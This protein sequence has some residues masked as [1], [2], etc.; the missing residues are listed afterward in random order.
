MPVRSADAVK[1]KKQVSQQSK[2]IAGMQVEVVTATGYNATDVNITSSAHQVTVSVLNSKLN[3]G[4]A[5]GREEQ[6]ATIASAVA[7]TIR[8]K[9]EF[10]QVI[11]IHVDYLK[12]SGKKTKAVQRLDFFKTAAGEFRQHK[13]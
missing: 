1:D 8:D 4:P 12:A 5:G 3:V 13:T 9:S 6:A 2:A 7:T 11:V 10:D